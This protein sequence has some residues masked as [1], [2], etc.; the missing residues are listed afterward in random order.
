MAEVVVKLL[1]VQDVD[2]IENNLEFFLGDIPMKTIF[3]TGR[4]IVS[5]LLLL[6]VTVCLM[7]P[8]LLSKAAPLDTYHSSWHL[9]RETADEDGA[10]F[11][12]VY[13]LTGLSTT[14]SGG[15]FAGK[16]T[17]TVLAGGAFKIPSTDPVGGHE[18]YSAGSKWMF[19]FCAKNYDVGADNII[20]NTFSYSIVGWSKTNGMLQNIVAGT[21]TLGTQAVVVYPDSGDAIGALVDE[22]LVVY[23]HGNEKFT[24]TNESFDG[25]VAGMVA[26]VITDNDSNLTSGYYAVTTATNSNNIVCSGI[27]S[28]S[29]TT[30]RVQINPA[31]WADTLAITSLVKWP[32]DI[33]GDGANPQVYNSAANEVCF[34]VLDLTGIE[35]I[36]VIIYDA[37]PAQTVEAGDITVYG[38]RF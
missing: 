33:W 1:E 25:V 26:R 31:F 20:D 38:R 35:W 16:D 29:D 24:V 34:L 4:V 37:L 15:N 28:S 9:V 5:V 13:D 32:L 27:S 36:Q 21:G 12:A 11:A 3:R 7:L 14:I 6:V 8:V 30:A 10:S 18:G 23:D 17:S 19:A 22:S 2:V